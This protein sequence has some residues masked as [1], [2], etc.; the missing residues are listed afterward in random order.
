RWVVDKQQAGLTNADLVSCVTSTPA[1]ILGWAPYL[2]SL[3][4]EALADVLVIAGT[5]EDPY[6]QLIKARETDIRLLVIHG[7][8]RYGERV[9]MEQLHIT[10]E[11]PLESWTLAGSERAFNLGTPDSELNDL[12]FAAATETLLTAMSDLPA[13]RAQA[14][15]DTAQ[16][17]SFGVEAPS[18][19]VDLDNEYEPTPEELQGNFAA[20]DLMADWSQIANS[21]VLDTPTVAEEDY[22]QRLDAASN[23]PDG[24]SASLRGAYGG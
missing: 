9:L 4:E 12:S 17:A 1:E 2:G 20:A 16:L 18:F 14:A 8:A 21:V 5:G 3:A 7:V 10:P 11:F 24:L 6:E 15:N 19:T 22:W 13:F 23:L